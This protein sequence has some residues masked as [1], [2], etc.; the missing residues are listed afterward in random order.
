MTDGDGTPPP[1][2]PPPWTSVTEVMPGTGLWH[3]FRSWPFW[4]QVLVGLIFLPIT[5]AVFTL[6]RPPQARRPWWALTALAVVVW[7]IAAFSTSDGGNEA[8]HVGSVETTT[9][10][11]SRTSVP[12]SSTTEAALEAPEGGSRSGDGED[13]ALDGGAVGRDAL[14]RTAGSNALMYVLGSLTVEPEGTNGG[15]A[16]DLFPQWDDEDVDGCDSRCEVLTSQRGSDGLWLSEWDG[17]RTDDTSELQV[18]HVVALAEAW[19]SGAEAWLLA[20]RD[21]FAD[22]LPNLIAVSAAAN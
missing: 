10:G 5:L 6:T 16:R 21:E 7:G 19:E 8:V 15:Y 20:D 17:Y 14:D 13:L 2:P 1:P 9:T 4:A 18:D 22:H 3:R 11:R 12:Q